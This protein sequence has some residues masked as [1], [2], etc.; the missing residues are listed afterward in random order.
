M[1]DYKGVIFDLDGTLIDSMWIWED[2]DRV[3][4]EARG[5][6]LPIDLQKDI[7]GCSFSETALYFKNRFK[8]QEDIETIKSIWIEMTEEYY[9]KD[10]K[11]KKGVLELLEA[12]KLKGIKLG[13]ATSNSRI[14]AEKALANNGILDFF[15]VLVTSCDVKKGK[16][17]PD[18]FLEAAK[19]MG[20]LAEDCLVF[21]DTH[22]GVLGGKAAGMDVVAIYD[23][24]SAAYTHLIKE[25]ADLYLNCFSEWV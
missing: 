18:V 6:E 14:L 3:F 15:H 25:D 20:I 24:L 10:I 13:V 1:E 19:Q 21:E 7:E 17:H 11:L 22:A 4:L 8:L 23:P 12:F 2:I 9:K 16:P 5:H